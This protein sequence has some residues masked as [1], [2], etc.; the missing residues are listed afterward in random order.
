MKK[1]LLTLFVL[2]S[3][4]LSL[5]AQSWLWARQGKNANH[6]SDQTSATSISM[7]NF[8]N[9]YETGQYTGDTLIFGSDTIVGTLLE[10]GFETF[11]V[12]YN[13]NGNVIWAQS[14]HSP[15]KNNTNASSSF[16]QTDSRANAYI[17]GGFEDTL[18]FQSFPV[19]APNYTHAYLVKYDANG[20]VKW[21]KQSTTS[22]PGWGATGGESIAVD[23]SDNIYLTGNYNRTATF[24]ADT[25]NGITNPN[26][27][28]VK[29]D[30]NGNVIWAKQG[31]NG[32]QGNSTGGYVITDNFGYVYVT[33]VFVDSIT[34]G[35]FTLT[36]SSLYQGN[37]FIVKYDSSGNVIWAKQGII[38]KGNSYSS[39]F[40]LAT[41]N[42]EH[43]YVTGYFGDTLILGATT[44]I[45]P[46]Y[47]PTS[48]FWAKYDSAGNLIW[49]KQA[50]NL[51]SLM[52]QGISVTTDGENNLYLAGTGGGIGTKNAKIVFGSDTITGKD[53]SG[54]VWLKFDSSGNILNFYFSNIGTIDRNRTVVDSSGCFVYW[55]GTTGDT[56]AVFGNDTVGTNYPTGRPIIARWSDGECT[57]GINAIKSQNLTL[58]LYPNP[59]NKLLNVNFNRQITGL[60]TLSIMDITGREVLNSQCSTLNAEKIP[61]AIGTAKVSQLTI[62][63]SSL[64]PAMY[65][66]QIKNND[67]YVTQKFIK[68]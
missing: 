8:H 31:R 2:S 4:L 48:I 57:D 35:S 22:T 44:L 40:A 51:D 28:L 9:V 33:G 30:T 58:T 15:N 16:V 3:S 12:K 21:A 18:N 11:L 65:F 41:D 27:F 5:K 14:S 49:A 62:D 37:L 20:N 7:D 24:G 23:N 36:N 61:V 32:V 29:Y 13:E 34:F 46:Y 39:G 55:G 38:P 64:P 17:T 50:Y 19:Y 1:T 56:I 6:E 53:K 63:V 66:I 43:I 47:G 10:S 42:A 45:C 68:L 60:A 67:T 59:T 26:F 25:L 52:W 54:S